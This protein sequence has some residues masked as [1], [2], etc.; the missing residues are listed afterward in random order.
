VIKIVVV[1]IL[2][3]NITLCKTIVEDCILITVVREY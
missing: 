3:V 1:F 2:L